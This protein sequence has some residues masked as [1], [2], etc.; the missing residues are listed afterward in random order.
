MLLSQGEEEYQIAKSRRE[1]YEKELPA[2]AEGLSTL[3]PV[4]EAIAVENRRMNEIEL[5]RQ[6]LILRSPVAGQVNQLLCRRGQAVV[7]GEPIM[8]IVEHA[9]REILAYLHEADADAARASTRVLESS[10]TSPEKV[11]ES[12]IVRVGPA[13]E[14]LPPRLWR[15]PRTPD[16]GRAVVIAGVPALDLTPGELVNVRLLPSD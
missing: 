14:T 15:D 11:V 1:Q 6:A 8:T 4:M 5:Q 7:P 9:P 12:L 16:Y 13:I 10:R 2:A 3:R